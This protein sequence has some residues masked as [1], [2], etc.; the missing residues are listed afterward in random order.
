MGIKPL[1]QERRIPQVHAAFLDSAGERNS[2]R[3]RCIFR[4]THINTWELN[5]FCRRDELWQEHISESPAGHGRSPSLH[6]QLYGNRVCLEV[7]CHL[8]RRDP[9]QRLEDEASQLSRGG[10]DENVAG[11]DCGRKGRG[12]ERAGT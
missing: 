3:A 9:L 12:E 5:L 10:R 2:P 7:L 4:Q 1:L 8:P 6:L 11:G